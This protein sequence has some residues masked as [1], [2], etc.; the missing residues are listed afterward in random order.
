MR[1]AYLCNIYRPS[2][3]KCNH[4][5]WVYTKTKWPKWLKITPRINYTLCR[6]HEIYDLWWTSKCLF[7][8]GLYIFRL[9]PKIWVRKLNKVHGQTKAKPRAYIC[10]ICFKYPWHICK[11]T[12]IEPTNHMKHTKWA[13][14][15]TIWRQ[16]CHNVEF[17][18]RF[19]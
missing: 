16:R 2:N 13:F 1:S 5:F 12:S 14:E 8:S 19:G 18:A 7:I 11:R 6:I 10:W 3:K 15:Y 17:S 4:L 9:N